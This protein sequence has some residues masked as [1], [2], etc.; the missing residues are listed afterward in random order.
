MGTN[1]FEG[2]P[3]DLDLVRLSRKESGDAL[4]L[5]S[6]PELLVHIA[7]AARRRFLSERTRESLEDWAFL[8]NEYQRSTTNAEAED[9]GSAEWLRRVIVELEWASSRLGGV[10]RGS[11]L[12]TAYP[13]VRSVLT[14]HRLSEITAQFEFSWKESGI[15]TAR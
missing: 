2:L 12:D 3:D 15:K 5:A 4:G 14:D 6:D 1:A 10:M 13:R 11:W 8:L 9:P 7:N